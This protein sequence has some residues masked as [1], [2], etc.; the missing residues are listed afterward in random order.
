MVHVSKHSTEDPIVWVRTA[1][2]LWLL[3][4]CTTF[5]QTQLLLALFHIQ[6]FLS[7]CLAKID[8]S[9]QKEPSVETNRYFDTALE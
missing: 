7:L 2:H 9:D 6:G 8:D 4:W 5:F 1:F 3:F